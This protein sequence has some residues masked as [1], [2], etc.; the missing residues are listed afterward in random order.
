[1]KRKKK[2]RKAKLPKGTKIETDASGK[3]ILFS[4]EDF[5]D[6]LKSLIRENLSTICLGAAL[7][8]GGDQAFSYKNTLKLFLER[9]KSKSE[10][11]KKGMLGDPPDQAG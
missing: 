11:T 5:C 10:N 9:Y 8:D 7:G 3:S 2:K 1:M 6:S 4:I